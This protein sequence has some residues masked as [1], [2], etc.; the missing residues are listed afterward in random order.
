MTEPRR[1]WSA[2]PRFAPV[3]GAAVGAVAGALYWLGAQVWPTSVAVVVSMAATELL[4]ARRSGAQGAG[5]GWVVFVF[6]VLVKY[7]AL[8][9]LSSASLPFPLPANLALGLIMIAGHACSR[10]LDIFA[11]DPPSY[12]DLGVAWALGFAPA[13]LIGIPGLIGL[14]AA[15]AAR[16][17]AIAFARRNRDSIPTHDMNTAPQTEACFYLGTLAAWSY[18]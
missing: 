11:L 13:M 18:V 12:S 5:P 17:V 7:N 4:F 15:I 3:L 10:A 2:A 16:I 8:M 1:H 14:A 9:A 6:V